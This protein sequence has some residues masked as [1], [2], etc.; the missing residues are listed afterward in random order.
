MLQSFGGTELVV[1]WCDDR[2]GSVLR[3]ADEKFL[4]SKRNVIDG[5]MYESGSGQLVIDTHESDEKHLLSKA[6]HV[7]Q[8][9]YRCRTYL[10]DL[11][12]KEWLNQRGKIL[13]DHTVTTAGDVV[14]VQIAFIPG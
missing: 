3:M 13:I 2:R 14:A 12:P 8:P 4:D 10:R 1:K 6:S 11:V 9:L 5:Y 7:E